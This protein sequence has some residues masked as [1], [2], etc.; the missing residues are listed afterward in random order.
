MVDANVVPKGTKQVHV[1][2][3]CG[4]KH[5]TKV[6]TDMRVV[7][8]NHKDFCMEKTLV[9]HYLQEKGLKGIFLPNSGGFRS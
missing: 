7:L 5:S 4:D 1:L 6:A 9:E 2:K 3:E 8:A